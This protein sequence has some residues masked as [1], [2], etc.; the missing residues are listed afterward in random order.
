[1]LYDLYACIYSK[2]N[3]LQFQTG[4]W[5]IFSE[6]TKLRKILSAH[7]HAHEQLHLHVAM[8]VWINGATISTTLPHLCY[9]IKMSFTLRRYKTLQEELKLA[10][11][12]DRAQ[13]LCELQAQLDHATKKDVMQKLRPFKVGKRRKDLG[14]RPLQ[15]VRLEDGELAQSPEEAIARWRRHYAQMEAGTVVSKEELFW[16]TQTTSPPMDISIHEV[17]SI[18][19]LERQLRAARTHRA[20]GLDQLPAE[21]LHGAPRQLAFHL[22]P[23]FIK[24]TLTISECIQHKGGQLVSIYKRKGEI[25]E[26]S[27][28]RALLVSSCLSKAF[29]NTFRQRTVPFVNASSGAMQISSQTRPSVLTAAHAVRA[30]MNEARR[31]GRSSFSLFVDISQAYYRVIRQFAYG[32]DLS[33]EHTVSFLRQIGFEDFCLQDIAEMMEETN[34]L[35]NIGCPPFLRKQVQA[36][37]DNTWFSLAQDSAFIRTRRGTRPGD[38]YADIIWSLVFAKWIKRLET[39][40]HDSEAFP[41]KLWNGQ[42]GVQSEVGTIPVRS[43]LV[44]WA[45]DVAILG[46]SDDAET[47]V[48]KLAF[49]CNAMVEELC[50]FGLNPNF[51]DGKTEAVIDL[52]GPGA[53]KTR[54]RIFTQQQCRLQLQTKLPDQPSLKVVARY[55][56]LGGLISHGARIHPEISHRVG[57]ANRTFKD[58]QAKIFRNPKVPLE[59]RLMVL[60]ATVMATLQYGAGTWTRLTL[61][62]MQL[63]TSSHMSF[64]RRL[65]YRLHHHS[66]VR[67]MT[68]SYILATLEV[69]HPSTTLRLLRLRWYGSC[70]QLDLPAFWSIL[71]YERYWL[72]DVAQDLQWMYSQIK[73]YTGLPDPAVHLDTWHLYSPTPRSMEKASQKNIYALRV[74]TQSSPPC[75]RLSLPCSC[76]TC[77]LRPTHP[78]YAD[79]GRSAGTPLL[80]L[81]KGLSFFQCLGG[82]LVQKAQSNQQMEEAARRIYM[83]GLRQDLS[84]WSPTLQTFPFSPKLLRYAGGCFSMGSCHTILWQ[85]SGLTTGK[86]PGVGHLGPFRRQHPAAANRMDCYGASLPVQSTLHG[87]GLDQTGQSPCMPKR[88][89]TTTDLWKWTS[90]NSTTATGLHQWGGHPGQRWE[91]LCGAHITCQANQYHSG[92]VADIEPVRADPVLIDGTLLEQPAATSIEVPVHFTPSPTARRPPL[93]H[94]RPTCSWRTCILSGVH[95]PDPMQWTWRS[96]KQILA[97]VLDRCLTNRHRL[98]SYWRSTMWIMVCVKMEVLLGTHWTATNSWW[99]GCGFCHM[100]NEPCSHQRPQTVGLCQP[101]FALHGTSDHHAGCKSQ[102]LPAGLLEHP[103]CPPC[104]PNGTQPASIWLLPILAYLL[105]AD[106]IHKVTVKQGYWGALSPKPT[107]LLVVAPETSEEQILSQLNEHRSTD[108]LP[109][110]LCMGKAAQGG[111]KTAPL[112]RYTPSFCRGLSSI[113]QHAAKVIPFTY[114]SSDRYFQTFS[115]L[116]SLYLRSSD[117]GNA[118]GADYVPTVFGKNK[119]FN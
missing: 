92:K 116:K 73:G 12:H 57:Q 32:A 15:V 8:R 11:S 45:D 56:H 27:N 6:R 87:L 107:T 96:H 21:L 70:L 98:W 35:E 49:T 29:H 38:G 36:L 54:R 51:R 89:W 14:K 9:A 82:T 101:T 109:E 46:Q 44:V 60:N 4:T 94:P 88:T 16:Q 37:H 26:C 81:Q 86:D 25:A 77:R 91:S 3:S 55:K 115:D 41:E 2:R 97:K 79:H 52:R 53:T 106:N 28:H 18:F 66:D 104:R 80:Y 111:Y 119:Q 5:N 30:H 102:M 22:W 61:K 103:A 24:Q 20:M 13:H 83:L 112:K 105:R 31:N 63:W 48:S 99:Y 78:R 47:L 74:A 62:D 65:F 100:G 85:Q 68:D 34:A 72:D 117:D 43:A 75:C 84:F 69:P 76:S 108:V 40:L 39:R 95:R 58:Y 113:F 7:R 17:P 23:W 93:H 90:R 64:Y 10:I 71:A 42:I 50:S 1:M 59:T 110:P 118:D 33:D 19:E 114:S 67:H